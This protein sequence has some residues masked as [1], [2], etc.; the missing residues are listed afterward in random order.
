MEKNILITYASKHGAT[1]EIAEKIG[2]VLRQAGLHVDVI[3]AAGVRDLNPYMA[4]ILGSA[5][6]VGKWHK[7]AE[8]FIQA[9]EKILADRQV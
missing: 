1:K 2:A 6:Y 3:P 4:I 9:N 5:V 7:D 8:K